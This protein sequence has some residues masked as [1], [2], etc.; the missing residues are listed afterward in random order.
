MSGLRGQTIRAAIRRV[1][2]RMPLL[3]KIV[4]RYRRLRRD[5]TSRI[6]VGEAEV[7][8]PR[9][10]RWTVGGGEYYERNLTATLERLIQMLEQPVVYDVGA[11]FGFYTV[12]L[13]DTAEWV[14]AFE[15]VTAT[16]EVLQENIRRNRLHNVTAFE[17]ALFDT[18]AEMPMKLYSSSGTDSLVWTLPSDHPAKLVGTEMVKVTTL[19]LAVDE[20][21]LRLPDLIKIDVEGAE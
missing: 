8:V 10:M 2:K 5:W 19:D 3:A 21:R 17:L 14:Y 6:R 4:H 13:C 9:E 11:N 15:P 12:K 7:A 18:A 20:R 16:F 1:G